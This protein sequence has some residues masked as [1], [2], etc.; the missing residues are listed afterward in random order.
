V[1]L[2]PLVLLVLLLVLISWCGSW[3]AAGCARA[4]A[5]A[6]VFGDLVGPLPAFGASVLGGMGVLA[7]D[8]Y[9]ITAAILLLVPWCC[10]LSYALLLLLL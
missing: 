10:G 9:F 7:A 6:V 3:V 1:L 2:V 4:A 5:S 8:A